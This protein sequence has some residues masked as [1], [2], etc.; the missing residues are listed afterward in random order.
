[1]PPSIK[2]LP[3]LAFCTGLLASGSAIALSQI[4]DDDGNATGEIRDGIVAV[5]LPPLPGTEVGGEGTPAVEE[6]ETLDPG[7]SGE[8]DVPASADETETPAIGPATDETPPTEEPEGE[9]PEL[10]VEE[11]A[12]EPDADAKSSEG[13]PSAAAEKVKAEPLPASR[14][15]YDA[16]SLPRPV[17]DLRARLIDISRGG[18]IEKLRPYIETGAEETVLSFGGSVEDPIEFLKASSGDEDGIEMLAILLELLQAG[19][20]VLEPDTENAIYI[21]P[22]FAQARLDTLTK[23]Q[24]V[25][26]FEIVTA[27]DYQNMLD[28]GA[29]NFYR[30]GITPEGKL[31]YFVAGD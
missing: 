30:L 21:W 20:V 4:V 13:S 19:H 16:E 29:Y 9:E 10:P 18:E 1:M 6:G 7:E 31:A 24:K 14:V 11:P 23:P 17:R 8:D 12:A 5:P 25:E 26:L 3:I 15:S 28:F 22:Y 2:A 27:G